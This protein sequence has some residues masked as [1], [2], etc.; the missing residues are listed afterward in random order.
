MLEIFDIYRLIALLPA[1]LLVLARVAGLIIFAPFFGSTAIPLR[2]RLA[3]V[4]LLSLALF[5]L[6]SGPFITP[7][8]LS[9]FV[10]ALLG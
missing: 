9:C 3:L 4:V 2:F 8:C 5:T 7:A 6:V 10:H 1:Y